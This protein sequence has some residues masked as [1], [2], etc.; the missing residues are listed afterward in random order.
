[1]PKNYVCWMTMKEY[2]AVATLRNNH[3]VFL[4][5]GHIS[6]IDFGLGLILSLINIVTCNNMYIYMIFI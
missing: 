1:V 4:N 5:A 3:D 6:N 2:E